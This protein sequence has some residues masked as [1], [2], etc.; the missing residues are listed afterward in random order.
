MRHVVRAHVVVR[1]DRLGGM[2]DAHRCGVQHEP[3][4]M[5]VSGS[6]TR[7]AGAHAAWPSGFLAGSGTS[8]TSAP[9]RAALDG[10]GLVKL[11]AF[12]SAEQTEP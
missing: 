12:T 9:G 8:M 1:V 5:L 10:D 4:D 11:G 2:P 7:F 6:T 3:G